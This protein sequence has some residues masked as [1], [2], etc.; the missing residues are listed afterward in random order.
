VHLV[1]EDASCDYSSHE[2]RGNARNTKAYNVEESCHKYRAEYVGF[3]P[4][5]HAKYLVGT[6]VCFGVDKNT[7][8]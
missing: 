3:F 4:G 6:R 5:R 2:I 1:A 8:G 7:E